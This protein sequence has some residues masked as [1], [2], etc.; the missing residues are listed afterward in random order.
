MSCPFDSKDA[1]LTLRS[2]DGKEF[3]VH[4]IVLS[5]PLPVFGDVFAF[6]HPH[7]PA[8][9]PPYVYLPQITTALGALF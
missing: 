7:D 8:N 5:V 4:G 6:P 3:W 1:D 9:Q 2:A